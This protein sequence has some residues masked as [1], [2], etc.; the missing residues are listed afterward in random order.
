MKGFGRIIFAA[1][2]VLAL[3]A[4]ARGIG[5]GIVTGHEMALALGGM[6]N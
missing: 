5:G 2:A 3:V 4:T 6:L 1:L